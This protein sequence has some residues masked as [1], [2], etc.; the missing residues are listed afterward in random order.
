MRAGDSSNNE[1]SNYFPYKA[2]SL[3]V[4]KGVIGWDRYDADDQAAMP[5]GVN[6]VFAEAYGMKGLLIGTRMMLMIR[7]PA[8]WIEWGFA[9]D[10]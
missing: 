7:H 1:T 9:W 2:L 5:Y 3:H 8:I 10:G 6:G 4:G